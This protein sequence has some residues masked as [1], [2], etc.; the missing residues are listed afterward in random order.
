MAKNKKAS[1]D[2]LL[3]PAKADVD[4][5]L[6][7]AKKA[8]APKAKNKKAVVDDLLGPAKKAKKA[9]A[10]KAKRAYVPLKTPRHPAKDGL[11]AIKSEAG[12]SLGV[13][14]LICGTGVKYKS[15]R[16]PILCRKKDCFKAYRNAYR[17]DYVKA[18]QAAA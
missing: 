6:G 7:P 17:R 18:T 11:F 14:C 5:L 12:K 13:K 9:K 1:V 15:G 10:P 2:D 4:D 16:P 3:G 8:K